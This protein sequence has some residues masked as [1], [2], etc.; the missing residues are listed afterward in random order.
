MDAWTEYW[1]PLLSAEDTRD[2]LAWSVFYPYASF[3]RLTVRGFAFN[4]W[5]EDRRARAA[6]GYEAGAGGKG[7]VLTAEDRESI[8]RAA[9][10]AEEMMLAVS[11]E[12]KN[13]RLGKT[14]R[15]TLWD[16]GGQALQ[17][18]PAVVESLK[19]ASD[20]L[21]CVVS[22]SL[23]D[24]DFDFLTFSLPI[25]RCSAILSS[26]SPSSPTKDFFDLISLSSRLNPQLSY[27]HPCFRPT[28]FVDSSSSAQ[29]SSNPSHRVLLIQQSSKLHSSARSG[30]QLSVVVD[31][32]LPHLLALV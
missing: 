25:R 3:S 16:G 30:T 20:S 26:F 1:E 8:A 28:S 27:Q 19:M 23:L 4:R 29:T 17:P 11:T 13:W 18:D 22:R 24:S 15:D 6:A 12:G 9:K 5:K 31:Q 14:V 7:P 10:M 2:P 32:L 21:T